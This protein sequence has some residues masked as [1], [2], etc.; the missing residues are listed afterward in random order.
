VPGP[1]EDSDVILMAEIT[2]VR[3]KGS[4]VTCGTAN[5]F[6]GA[7]YTG[8][9]QGT[10]T[11]RITDR[12]NA[13]GAGGGEDAATVVDIPFPM[14][15]VCTNSSS[16]AVGGLCTANTTFNAIVPN[17][18]REGKRS[19][20]D[21]GQIVIN[22]GGSDGNVSTAPNTRFMTQGVFVP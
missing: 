17:A 6:D 2:D 11:I 13:V 10:A 22:D 5:M 12:W 19:V 20:L 3:C 14:H 1:P 16:T 21:L 7:D 15:M 4:T 8:Q 18:L 9:L